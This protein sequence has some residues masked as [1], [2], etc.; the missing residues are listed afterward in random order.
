[1]II[2][3]ITGGIATGKSTV[4]ALLA[5]KGAPTISADEIAHAQL[6][7]GTDTTRAV[8]AAFPECSDSAGQGIDRQALGRVIFADTD[9]RIRLEALTHPPI[10]A[11]LQS[12]IS[13]WRTEGP[14]IAVAEIP[15]LFEADLE[16]LVDVVV[17]V[18]CAEAVQ[19]ARLL[20]RPGMNDPEAHRRIAAQM[21]LS[22]K[23]ARA[24]Q[25]ITTDIG[26]ED[27]RRQLQEFW[28]LLCH[29]KA[30]LSG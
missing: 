18:S 28:D 24:D 30:S 3:G 6:A 29:N 22:K 25:V 5:E 1:M 12:M 20:A 4:T 19:L 13:A 9:A 10:I 2:L 15:L 7:P 8:L 27:T 26:M 17:V 21:P 23:V 11:A 14:G 16:Q